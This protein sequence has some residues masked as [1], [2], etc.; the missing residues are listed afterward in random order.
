MTY[1]WASKA[2]STKGYIAKAAS[3][4]AF[5][6]PERVERQGGQNQL[7][8][9]STEMDLFIEK[10]EEKTEGKFPHGFFELGPFSKAQQ[11]NPKALKTTR[12][13]VAKGKYLP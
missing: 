13:Y 1:P 6:N 9:R 5:L 7:C 4:S 12:R 2:K 10:P 8:E 11:A 3:L